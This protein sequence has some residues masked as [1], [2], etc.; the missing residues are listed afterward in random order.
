ML[1]NFQEKWAKRKAKGA[2]IFAIKKNIQEKG[3][4]FLG[5]SSSSSSAF[6]T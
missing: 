6:S 3:L 1:Y 2:E 5:R 4:R